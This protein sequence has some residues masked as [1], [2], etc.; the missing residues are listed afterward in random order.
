[1]DSD[2]AFPLHLLR[3][4]RR[5]LNARQA[6]GVVDSFRNTMMMS[7]NNAHVQET[8]QSRRLRDLM[9]LLNL[10]STSPMTAEHDPRHFVSILLRELERTRKKTRLSV[11]C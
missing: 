3:V 6:C 7:R 9:T 8:S 5:P 10:L 4:D 11:K 2:M 1:M